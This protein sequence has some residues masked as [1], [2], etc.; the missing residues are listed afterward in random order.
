ME[1]FTP[2]WKSKN[3]KKSALRCTKNDQSEK[4]GFP[5]NYITIKIR[6]KK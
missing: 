6:K 5:I 4:M 2:T 3:E 1:L